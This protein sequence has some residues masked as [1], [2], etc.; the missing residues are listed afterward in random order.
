M[1]VAMLTDVYKPV[2]NGVTNSVALCKRE[3]ESAGHQVYVFTFG[4]LKYQDEE[5]HIYRSPALP[6]S[7]TGYYIGLQHSREARATLG[8]MDILHAH[9][10]FASG[11]LAV[12]YGR[13]LG[14]PVIFT[15]HTRYDLHAQAYLRFLPPPLTQVA[16]ETL[17]PAFVSQCDLVI[18]PSDGLRRVALDWGVR[19]NVVVIPNGIELDRFHYREAPA[20]RRQ[21]DLPGDATVLVYCG[22][23]GPEKNLHFLMDAF[24]GAVQAV[25][26]AFLLIVGGGPEEK[27]LRERASAVPNVRFAGPVDYQ[28]VPRYLAAGDVFVTASVTEVHPLSVLEALGAGLPVLGIDSPGISDTVTDGVEGYVARDGLPAY[29]ALMVRMLLEPDRRQV[30]A[31]AA[32]ERSRHYDIKRTAAALLSHYERLLETRKATSRAGI[33]P[34]AGCDEAGKVHGE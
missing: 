29:T 31:N 13:Q 25:P 5:T 33:H 16:L 19:E 17:M 15:N 1:K 23:L 12:H 28:E 4:H 18:A 3:M 32:I 2:I 9:H 6:L 8:E 22:R 10:P 24:A 14:L 26:D 21:L 34:Q 30:M 7:D 11:L 20:L 27:A